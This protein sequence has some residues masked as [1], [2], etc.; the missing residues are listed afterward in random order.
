MNLYYYY[1]AVVVLLLLL[2]LGC[3]TPFGWNHQCGV[4]LRRHIRAERSPQRWAD[5]HRHQGSPYLYL[6]GGDCNPSEYNLNKYTNT[7]TIWTS[8]KS[9]VQPVWIQGE[10]TYKYKYTLHLGEEDGASVTKQSLANKNCYMG[11]DLA[12]GCGSHRGVLEP[13]WL[14][15]ESWEGR[16]HWCLRNTSHG[17][18]KYHRRWR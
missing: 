4:L 11:A 12:E 17:I 13:F 1:V 5:C 15:N 2:L 7:I 6:G 8:V 16:L 9:M 3:K 14:L 18:Q 10:Q